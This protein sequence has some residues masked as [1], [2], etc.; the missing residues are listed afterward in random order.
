MLGWIG[1]GKDENEGV[2]VIGFWN[3]VQGKCENTLL[4]CALQACRCQNVFGCLSFNSLSLTSRLP[5]GASR[6]HPLEDPFPLV[7][8]PCVLPLLVQPLP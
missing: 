5:N 8:L 7:E 3:H 2:D 6:P 1:L 4:W